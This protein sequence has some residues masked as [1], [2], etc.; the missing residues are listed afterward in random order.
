M[1]GVPVSV[2]RHLL[3]VG[4]AVVA[5]LG[6]ASPAL[7]AKD[8]GYDLRNA[9]YCEILE[10]KSLPPG[11]EVVV[12]NTIGLN[13][14]PKD[15]WNDFDATALAAELGDPYVLLNGPRHFLMDSA[16]ARTGEIR[17]F[18]GEKMRKV[19]TLPIETFADL[20]Q[21]P[22][23]ERTVNRSNDWHWNAG[24][25]VYE[26]LAPD[27]ST[28]VMQAYSQIVDPS[29]RMKDLGRLGERL[30]LPEGW[31]YRARKLEE[32]LTLRAAG[33][34]TILQDELKNTYQLLPPEKAKR[35]KVQIS[36]S[37]VTRTI[38]A[39]NGSL[40]DQGTIVGKPFGSA[41]LDLIATFGPNSTMT[42]KFTITND[43]G[44]AYG[45]VDTTYVI[46]AGPGIVFDGTGA[47]TGGTGRYR[48][49]RGANLV[50]H[51]ENTLDGQ[52]GR[53]TLT[54]AVRLTRGS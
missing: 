53:V 10:L 20:A 24:R 4:L 31:S 9:R 18:H 39:E 26:L 8:E 42:G 14:C 7:A 28:Y 13:D 1:R 48:G 15:W 23:V 6:F 19:A 49:I 16:K 47:F 35:K 45:T 40:H 27:G 21:I 29:L 41:Q 32:P 5:L 3:A 2:R 46:G 37:G 51:D 44:T 50:A 38:G 34:A 12:W 52:N 17:R 36:L 25:T 43:R 54:G 33:S 30:A 11:A 22:Y